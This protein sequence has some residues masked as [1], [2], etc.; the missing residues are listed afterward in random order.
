MR[1][2]FADKAA[3]AAGP[4]LAV[5]AM[6]LFGLMLVAGLALTVAP[7]S[8]S[9]TA[10]AAGATVQIGQCNSDTNI[11]GQRIACSV[12]IDNYYNVATGVASS[13]AV[14]VV[15]HSAAG[16]T[17]GTCVTTPQTNATGLVDSV[18]QCNGS[19]NGGGGELVCSVAIINHVVG[20]ITA[21]GVTVNQCIGSGAGGGASPLLC[22]PVQSTTSA[23][24]TQCNGSANGGGADGRVICTAA[25]PG[26][27]TRLPVLVN[28]CNDSE[29]GGGST[30]TCD[31]TVQNLVTPA[32]VVI[33]P[34]V[35][36][37]P[38]PTATPGAGGTTPPAAGP[39]AATGGPGTTTVPK[40]TAA[41]A[42]TRSAEVRAAKAKAS[43][44]QGLAFTGTDPMTLVRI[45]A[46]AVMLGAT[47]TLIES[48]RR[49]RQALNSK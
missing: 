28:Q 41:Q 21:T 9:D 8:M 49:S 14:L 5:R 22:D 18:N 38:T 19:G 37:P 42:A 47:L 6:L 4:W 17:T 7:G 43:A 46:G 44:A 16:V 34:V 39:P 1:N 15:C 12:A 20:D 27:G 10:S 25:V 32:A 35:V 13:V 23:T 26:A 30:V 45:T 29:N 48:R 36:V 33:P 40:E 2:I 24:V 31:Y 3:T 11:A